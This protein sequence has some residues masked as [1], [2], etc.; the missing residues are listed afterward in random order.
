MVQ[1][2]F[3]RADVHGVGIGEEGLAA[4]IL[5]EVHQHPGIT[6]PQMGHV[7]QL[8]KVNFDGNEFV[9]E[10]NLVHAGA[11]HQP[12]QFL[13]Q[14]LGSAGAEVGKIDFGCHGNTS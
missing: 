10:V 13:G 2:I 7:A 3:P 6:G 5:D 9:F 11:E 8:A 4:Q 12:S 14:G 1:S